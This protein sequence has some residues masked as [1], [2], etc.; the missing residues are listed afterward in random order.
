MDMQRFYEEEEIF[1]LSD[2]RTLTWR[3]DRQRFESLVERV[4]ELVYNGNYSFN[5]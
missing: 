4:Q 3:N 2:A 5:E 1:V